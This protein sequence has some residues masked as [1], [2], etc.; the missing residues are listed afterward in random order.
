[1]AYSSTLQNATALSNMMWYVQS[2]ATGNVISNSDATY[3]PEFC[4]TQGNLHLSE[5]MNHLFSS[6]GSREV[7]FRKF[8]IHMR[9]LNFSNDYTCMI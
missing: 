5:V 7:G 6:S 1:V 3:F 9:I 2:S 4:S 8:C